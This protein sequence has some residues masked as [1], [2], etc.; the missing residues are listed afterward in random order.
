MKIII[1]FN[2]YTHISV[3]YAIETKKKLKIKQD[4]NHITTYFQ[5]K[6]RVGIKS[7]FLL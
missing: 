3:K 5:I 6:P 1:I 2:P 4:Y 7:L